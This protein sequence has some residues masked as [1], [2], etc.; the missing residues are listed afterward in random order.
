MFKILKSLSKSLS[1]QKPAAEAKKPATTAPKGGVLDQVVKGRAADMPA[2][3]RTPE[4]LC[5][6]T[7]K[8]SKDE[9]KA[10]LKLLFRRFNRGASSLDP[11]VRAEADIMLDAVVAVREKH[12]GEI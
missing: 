2:K 6:I 5:E 1:G 11:K 7:P 12:F 3:A 8:M 9:I 4:E 10:R